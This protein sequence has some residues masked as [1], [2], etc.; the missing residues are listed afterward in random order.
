MIQ[1]AFEST[2]FSIPP[3]VQAVAFWSAIVLPFIYLP[4]LA[5]GL[6]TTTHQ[7]LFLAL[8]GLNVLTVVLGHRH[9]R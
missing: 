5:L 8:V 2:E 4:L 3:L 9:E 7:I 1:T 6:E